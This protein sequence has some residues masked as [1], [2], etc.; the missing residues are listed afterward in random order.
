[1]INVTSLNEFKNALCLHKEMEQELWILGVALVCVMTF[2]THLVINE[3]S[4]T[5]WQII[6]NSFII[7]I[8]KQAGAAYAV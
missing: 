1:M 3:V 4:I 6:H 2:A 7:S 5:V 8:Q